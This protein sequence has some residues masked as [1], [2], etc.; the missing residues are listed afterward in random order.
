MTPPPATIFI[1]PEPGPETGSG[2][3]P[4]EE[5]ILRPEL[6]LYDLT[7]SQLDVNESLISTRRL[8]KAQGFATVGYGNPPGSNFFRDEFAPYYILGAGVKWNILLKRSSDS[9]MK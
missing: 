5:A 4:A 1:L 2:E 7:A 3:V 9:S 6:V 8:P